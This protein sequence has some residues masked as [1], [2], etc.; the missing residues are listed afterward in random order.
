MTPVEFC[1]YLKG[2]IDRKNPI[3]L[4]EIQIHVIGK[5]LLE[6]EVKNYFPK[7]PG[8]RNGLRLVKNI[9]EPL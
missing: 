2:Y 9:D 4:N 5:L 3:Y 8:L 7:V 1:V 6:M